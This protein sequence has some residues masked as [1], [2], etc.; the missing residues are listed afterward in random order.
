MP[1]TFLLAEL[2]ATSALAGTG[3]SALPGAPVRPHASRR[4]GVR[5]RPT[6]MRARFLAVTSN[7]RGADCRPC[8]DPC[9]C[10]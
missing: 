3:H 6:V 4:R 1:P 10:P 2:Y 5:H 8:P 9:P 7:P